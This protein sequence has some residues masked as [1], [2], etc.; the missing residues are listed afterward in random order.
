MSEFFQQPPMGTEGSATDQ[1]SAQPSGEQNTQQGE[2]PLLDKYERFKFGDQEWT[3]D[4]LKKAM[5]RQ[6]DYTKKT[7]AVKEIQKYYDNLKFDLDHVKGN[8]SLA[9]KFKE[10]YP[11]DFWPYLDYVM[12]KSEESNEMAQQ[13]GRGQTELPRELQER[14]DRVE[15]YVKEKEIESFDAQLDTTF[16]KLAQ[17][18][19]DGNEEIV[20]ARAQAILEANPNMKLDQGAWERLW[21]KSHD[22]VSGLIKQKQE[23]LFNTQ[24]EANSRA[25]DIGSGGG[26]PGSAPTRMKLKDVADFAINQ[27]K[28]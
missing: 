24:K 12:R 19:P 7:Q 18:Y 28:G 4:S 16:A 14:L 26:T 21:K 6:S 1:Q 8:P 27:I 23:K 11:K 22:E 13:Q 5:M 17:K 20:L 2:I 3:P 9:D 15:S 10:V 25:K